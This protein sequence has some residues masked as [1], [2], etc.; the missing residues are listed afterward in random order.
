MIISET[1]NRTFDLQTLSKLYYACPYKCVGTYYTNYDYYY[2]TIITTS[3]NV[4]INFQF[5][6]VLILLYN[7]Y[8]HIAINVHLES[9][10]LKY[11]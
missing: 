2:I 7:I 1:F 5:D 6:N 4:I 10:K 9:K 11:K 8:M 3:V